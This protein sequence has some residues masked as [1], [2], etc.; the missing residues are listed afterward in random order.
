M[1]FVPLSPQRSS[2]FPTEEGSLCVWLL[3]PT[4]KEGWKIQIKKK[5][6]PKTGAKCQRAAGA[7]LAAMPSSRQG[8][9]GI[10]ASPRTPP[11]P[12]ALG[13]GAQKA[14]NSR[15]SNPREEPLHA[16]R[17][18][19]EGEVYSKGLGSF[20]SFQ[21]VREAHSRWEFSFLG[22]LRCSHH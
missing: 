14:A 19:N 20:A 1:D 6:P 10:P 11:D 22:V 21:G 9:L 7:G 5:Q 2:N 8:G 16:K 15:I 17:G 18:E 4:G 13:S 12:A 3:N